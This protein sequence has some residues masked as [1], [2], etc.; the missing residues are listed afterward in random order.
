[1]RIEM[2][3]ANKLDQAKKQKE[4]NYWVVFGNNF[5]IV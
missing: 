1:M 2:F 3:D 4:N 5:Q